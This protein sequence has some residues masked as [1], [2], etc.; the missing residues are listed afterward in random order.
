MFLALAVK[1]RQMAEERLIRFIRDNRDRVASATIVNPVMAVKSLL[2][3]IEVFLNWKKIRRGLPAHEK[4][5][6]DRRPLGTRV[7]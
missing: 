3:C 6:L 5:A 7:V 4:I 1:D 2:E